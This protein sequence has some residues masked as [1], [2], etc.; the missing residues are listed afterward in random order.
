MSRSVARQSEIGQRI[1]RALQNSTGI[2]THAT[3]GQRVV[4]LNGRA[5]VRKGHLF[6][7][8]LAPALLDVQF[9]QFEQ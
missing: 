9:V 5:D 6:D 8:P 7:Y 2:W 1:V 3:D 4:C